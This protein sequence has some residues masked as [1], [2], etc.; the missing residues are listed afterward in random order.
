[1]NEAGV[2]VRVSPDGLHEP[3]EVFHGRTRELP[4]NLA[5]TWRQRHL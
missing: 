4:A 3:Y 5:R 2:V 1:M